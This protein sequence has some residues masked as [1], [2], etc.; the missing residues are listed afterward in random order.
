MPQQKTAPS[1]HH[2]TLHSNQSIVF[3]SYRRTAYQLFCSFQSY[4]PTFR[5]TFSQIFLVRLQDCLLWEIVNW[6]QNSVSFNGNF[7]KNH[8]IKNV[9]K[10]QSSLYNNLYFNW[11]RIPDLKS[12][13]I[14]SMASLKI[15][16][17]VARSSSFG[18]R[19]LFAAHSSEKEI[20]AAWPEKVYLGIMELF[21]PWQCSKDVELWTVSKLT[22]VN[23]STR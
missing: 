9:L 20:L 22:G 4:D 19:V 18:N 2:K 15:L 17:N 16:F 10:F 21:L 12:K 1:R 3:D 8:I 7:S 6:T 5:L 11:T 23:N 14:W 13:L